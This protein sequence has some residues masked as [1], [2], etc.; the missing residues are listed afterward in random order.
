MNQPKPNQWFWIQKSAK[1]RPCGC[2]TAVVHNDLHCWAN[3][4]LWFKPANIRK[5]LPSK[6]WKKIDKG[7]Q[8]ETIVSDFEFSKAWERK[9]EKE[10][11]EDGEEEALLVMIDLSVQ[12]C[13]KD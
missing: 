4:E 6:R 10:K 2:Q 3:F 11:R 7:T 13:S 1:E 12:P 9:D 5:C 8:L